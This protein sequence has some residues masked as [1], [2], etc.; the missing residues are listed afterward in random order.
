MGLNNDLAVVNQNENFN[1]EPN[2]V[3]ILDIV[4]NLSIAI[5]FNSPKLACFNL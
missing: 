2:S 3:M 4:K 1:S 5:A